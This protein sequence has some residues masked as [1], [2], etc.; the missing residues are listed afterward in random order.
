[1]VEFE[2]QNLATKIVYFPGCILNGRIAYGGTPMFMVLSGCVMMEGG[3]CG[4]GCGIPIMGGCICDCM[5][6][7]G[8]YCI[9]GTDILIG[10]CMGLILNGWLE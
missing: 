2:P 9:E 6:C 7:I 8:G 3:G 1:M 10:C 5:G 4:C